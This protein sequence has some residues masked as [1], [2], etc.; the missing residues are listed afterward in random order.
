M[1]EILYFVKSKTFFVKTEDNRKKH[2]IY[3]WNSG[4]VSFNMLRCI[5]CRIQNFNVYLIWNLIL[6]QYSLNY[7]YCSKH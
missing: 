6:G 7:G 4:S 3:H 5:Y 2:K 1:Q